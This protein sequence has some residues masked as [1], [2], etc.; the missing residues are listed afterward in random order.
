MCGCT[1][2]PFSIMPSRPFQVSSVWLHLHKASVAVSIW[3][4]IAYN[5]FTA[6]TTLFSPSKADDFFKLWRQRKDNAGM[7]FGD[8]K[9][10]EM[11]DVKQHEKLEE[12]GFPPLN[13]EGNAS[14][15]P[16]YLCHAYFSFSLKC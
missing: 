10:Y 16:F 3:V 8:D 5:I 2:H 7:P 13:K 12:M 6:V 14:V 9:M 15:Y 11:S 1:G 4:D